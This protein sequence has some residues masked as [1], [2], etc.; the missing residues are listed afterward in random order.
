MSTAQS[1]V[2]HWPTVTDGSRHEFC[3]TLETAGLRPRFADDRKKVTCPYCKRR[4]DRVD[5]GLPAIEPA[6]PN[7]KAIR[8]EKIR[9]EMKNQGLVNV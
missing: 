3:R 4:L 5:R 7:V 8:L 9:E 2:I 6:R 1:T